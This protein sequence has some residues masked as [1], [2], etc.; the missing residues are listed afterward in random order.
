MILS[1]AQGDS[2]QP[3]CTVALQERG[4]GRGELQLMELRWETSLCANIH[5]PDATWASCSSRDLLWG[6]AFT[7]LMAEL[8][9]PKQVKILP[10]APSTCL[11]SSLTVSQRGRRAL[12]NNSHTYGGLCKMWL[13]AP[14]CHVAACALVLLLSAST[15]YMLVF[16]GC[17]S[18]QVSMIYFPSLCWGFW[19]LWKGFWDW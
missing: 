2:Q 15:L 11:C 8:S 16:S 18:S 6:R 3:P 13:W 1:P 19:S 7:Q 4:K 14:A 17:G 5:R 9:L 10:A 12:G